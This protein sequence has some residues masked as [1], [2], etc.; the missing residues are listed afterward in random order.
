[1]TILNPQL[2]VKFNYDLVFSQKNLCPVE[3]RL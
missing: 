2:K 1:M 3:K